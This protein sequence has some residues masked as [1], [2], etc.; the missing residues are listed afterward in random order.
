MNVRIVNES[1]HPLP[2]QA[3]RGDAGVDV[4]AN[5][6]EPVTIQPNCRTLIS[7]GIRIGMPAGFECQV[8]SRSGLAAKH[9][10]MVL[11]SPGCVDSTYTGIIGVI[12]YNS[13][14]EPFTVYD[15]DRIAQLVFVP[16]YT[17]NFIEVESL[18]KTDRGSTGFGDSG[19]K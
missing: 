16:C 18:D 17:P 3:N 15:G 1:K 12:L 9:G 7:T 14:S 6:D 5:I 11:N 19:M 10:V 2:E 13:S 8:R 4:R